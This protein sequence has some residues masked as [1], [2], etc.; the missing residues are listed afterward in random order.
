VAG[1]VGVALKNGKGAVDLFQ[2]DHSRQLVG[3]RHLSEGED[4]GG[5]GACFIPEAVCWPNGE[6]E[7]LGIAILMILKE[8][9][10]VF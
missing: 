5:G 9:R 8:L 3:E 10:E 2:Q 7:R 4:R 6:D 1:V